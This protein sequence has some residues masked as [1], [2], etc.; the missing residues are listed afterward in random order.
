MEQETEELKKH[1]QI[2]LDNDDDVY[3]DATPLASKIPIVDYKIH[4]ERNKP[5]FKIIRAD[6]NHRLFMSF[7]KMMKNFDR[8]D[9]E[10]LWKI[11]KERFK[12]T[13]PKNYT[14]DYLLNTIKI[15]FKKPNVEANVWKDQK[16]K[17][18]L[19]K[20]KRWKL[21]DSCGV[22]YLNL[23]TTQMFL[24]VEKMYPLTHFTLEKMINDVRLKVDYESEMSLELLRL[25]RRQLNKGDS[26]L[27]GLEIV[28]ETTEKIVQIKSRIQAARDRKKS[29]ANVRHKPLEFQV[30]DKV[31]LK[32]LW[33][34]ESLMILLDEI[35]IDDKLHFVE[36]PVEI[37][38]RE[39]KRLKQSRILSSRTELMT[40]NLTFPLTHQL[41]WN[42]G[43]GS[44]PNVLSL[45]PFSYFPAM[46]K[47]GMKDR[48][49]TLS[50]NDLKD[51]VKTYCI[52]LDL[53]PCFLDP[54]FTMDRLPDGAIGIYSEFLWFFG[55]RVS[56]LT[57]LLYVL[58]Y[59]KVHISRLV[60]LGL[61]KVVSFEVV[62][63]DLNIIP[64]VTLFCVFQCLCKQGDWFSFSKR[65][66]T[67]DVYMDD[68]PSS[69]KKWKDKF[70]LID[71]RDIPEYLTWRHSYSCVSN[72][73]PTDGYDRNDM[74][75]LCARLIHLCGIREKAKIIKESHHLSLLLLERVSS[76]TTAQA[77]EG[78][79]ILLL[80]PDEI[81][82]SLSDSH[83]VKKSKG[84]SQ[85]SLPSKKRKLQKK[86]LEAG[87]SAL[88]LDH[89]EGIHMKVVSAPTPRLGKM[90][91]ALPSI[92]V[93]SASEPSHVGTLA[94]AS[95]SSRSLSLGGVVTSGRIRKFEVEVMRCQMDL[96]DCLAHSALARDAE[97]DQIP[98]D[99]FGIATRG[100]K[101]DLTLF[102]LALGPYHM[103]YPYEGVSYPLYTKEGKALDRTNTHAELKRTESFLLLELSNR[104]NVLSDLL[105]SHGYELNS[106]YTNLVSS[107][108][109]LQEKLNQKKG[110]VRLLRLEVTSLDDKLER[111]EGDYDSLVLTEE[112]TRIDAK[113]SK[114]ALTMRD[115]PN[116]L[117]LEKS[118][119][120]GYKDA[121]DGLRKEVNEFV[122]SG[123]GGVVRNLL[124][125]DEFHAALARVLSLDVNYGVERELRI[126]HTN[127]E[128]E[129]VVQQVFNFHAGAKAD[130]DKAL[131]NFPT[132]PFPFLNMIVAA[133]RALEWWRILDMSRRLI[134]R[135]WHPDACLARDI[136]HSQPYGQTFLVHHALHMIPC[137]LPLLGIWL[138]AD[139]CI[140][141]MVPVIALTFVVSTDRSLSSSI[142]TPFVRPSHRTA[143]SLL[144]ASAFLFCSLVFSPFA[145]YDPST[146]LATN[147]EST[148]ACIFS[149]FIFVKFSSRVSYS[150]SLFELAKF[151]R[152]AYGYSAPS[153]S[154]RMRH[155]LDPC[156]LDA[157]SVYSFHMSYLVLKFLGASVFVTSCSSML[158]P[159]TK[160]NLAPLFLLV[161]GCPLP[162]RLPGNQRALV[163]LSCFLGSI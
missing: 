125:S 114:Q 15:L 57:F 8:E 123:V 85:V 106:R 46:S 60:P 40:L 27:T 56:F 30:G 137:V 148:N 160:K 20:V 71:H 139:L 102:P 78:A 79:I 2:I 48:V 73:L 117:S 54:G 4:T 39:V 21:F 108:D 3:A 35:Y 128:F 24:L 37:M 70:F 107:K 25:V 69:L 29:Y 38:D 84:P 6:G 34:D 96:L 31:M 72:D 130:F 163:L 18:G 120:Q 122:G 75:R 94:P 89:A 144:K 146:W 151:S 155:A 133:S 156:S 5:Y 124:S 77:I 19:A 67:E 49:C 104:M 150:T 92:A 126:G 10:S 13:E 90:L 65:H 93:V 32:K 159:S 64:T 157:P 12:K 88:E 9:L 149:T 95:T 80:T 97:Y 43:G 110:D 116:E 158:S 16:G 1:L 143:V 145:S 134:S 161:H 136:R 63:R 101:I 98:D 153:G 58:K 14:D 112:L 105:V 154:I 82:T 53:H 121:I 52:P 127:V 100:E 74:E 76:H 86:A 44:G 36:E 28:H 132:T 66:N 55:V 33:S 131:V 142:S 11:I 113:L 109:L 42:S 62:C 91:G 111:L 135:F 115:L 119:S 51:L 141:A 103:T 152:R 41:L 68:G 50:K 47:N 118:K 87:S 17:Y 59:F 45:S 83:L 99:D 22:H 162:L 140:R 7:S 26:Q 129:A 138:A 23:L 147:F 61:N 81:A